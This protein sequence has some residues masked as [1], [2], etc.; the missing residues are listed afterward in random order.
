MG[1]VWSTFKVDSTV[2]LIAKLG[3]FLKGVSAYNGRV[4][5]YVVD[6]NIFN[7]MFLSIYL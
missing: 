7:D 1:Y 4:M 6:P 3:K 2:C 5:G